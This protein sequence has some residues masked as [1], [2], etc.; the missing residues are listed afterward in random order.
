MSY[1]FYL[2]RKE[3]GSLN[4]K[5]ILAVDIGG[6]KTSFGI[7]E[8]NGN[9]L[10]LIRE[11]TFGSR[12]LG[13]FEE[14][15]QKFLTADDNVRPDVLSI[16]VAGPVLENKVTLTNLSWE[17]DAASLQTAF[18][19]EKV[20]IINDLEATAYGLVGLSAE[21]TV[22]L[23]ESSETISGN[24]VVL[25]PG[26]GLGEA[27]IFWDGTYHR[28]FATEGGHSEFAPRTDLDV[29]LLH[30]L[31]Q[32]DAIIS[33]EHVVSGP[34][35]YRIYKFLRDAKGHKEPAWLKENFKNNDNP[36]A[37]ISHAAMRELDA[38]CSL[39]M[40]LF[41]SYMARESASLVLKHKAVGGLWL[42]GGIPPRIFPL[43]KKD[44]FREQFIQ[45]AHMKHLLE[46]VPIR[47]V[48]NSQAALI[49]AG[50]YG[51]FGAAE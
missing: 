28:P 15:L 26:T 43:L 38:T 23:F 45:N 29:E 42:G 12:S 6:T 18:N 25:A 50:Y 24:M 34:G 1:R 31:Q 51:A 35:I 8:V 20:S 49:G 30:Y 40:D 48:L 14:I 37:V 10:S 2:P 22:S 7:F 4:G 33:W 11:E 3:D 39:T 27:G 41:V 16:G 9:K 13:T 46:K 32:E 47:I 19:I 44:L 5:K 36:A 21:D 17:L